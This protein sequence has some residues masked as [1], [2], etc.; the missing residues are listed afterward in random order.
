[1]TKTDVFAGAGFLL[2][3]HAP[4]YLKFCS[5][6]VSYLPRT[7]FQR[8]VWAATEEQGRANC[9]VGRS[10]HGRASLD[11]RLLVLNTDYSINIR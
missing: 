8:A 9:S 5:W 2:G 1:M 4:N 3:D 7:R 6:G 11:P 10:A